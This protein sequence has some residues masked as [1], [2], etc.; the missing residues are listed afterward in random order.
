M[1]E[2]LGHKECLAYVAWPSADE[3]KAVDSTVEVVF[4]VNGKLRAK[5]SMPKDATKDQMI[6]LA[7]QN[8]RIQTY[9]TD[10]AIV[11]TIAVPGKLVNF[12]VKPGK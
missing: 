10:V 7:K 2:K 6:E 8:E 9:L 11:K 4:Q 12:V 5:V 3:S 1:W